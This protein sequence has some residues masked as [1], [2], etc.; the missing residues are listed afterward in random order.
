ML[1]SNL[2][3]SQTSVYILSDDVGISK[4]TF[5]QWANDLFLEQK[6]TTLEEFTIFH[7]IKNSAYPENWQSKKKLVSYLPRQI[8][9]D[10][11]LCDELFN[12]IQDKRSEKTKLFIGKGSFDCAIT[13]WNIETG[14]LKLN[15]ISE[16]KEK[17]DEELLV[18]KSLKKKLTLIFYLP[19]KEDFSKPIISFE[20][21]TIQGKSNEPLELNASFSGITKNISWTPSNFLSCDD[22][23]TPTAQVKETTTFTVSG[24]N[25]MGCESEKSSITVEIKEKCKDFNAPALLYKLK[26][27]GSFYKA[28]SDGYRWK[29][30]AIQPGSPEYY[31]VCMKNCGENFKVE[32]LD[33]NRPIW[34][35]TFLRE[36]IEEGQRPHID[37]PDKFIFKISVINVDAFR[38]PEFS[39]KFYKFRITSSDEDGN[40]YDTYVSPPTKFV[41]C[42]FYEY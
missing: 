40:N 18:N 10:Y 1:F 7:N 36:D 17:L 16:I 12:L 14:Q 24:E 23:K 27:A 28:M 11:V 2:I 8:N 30:A 5:K 41:D 34:G 15:S 13:N 26:G 6:K 32:I 31:L 42:G 20:E 22:C 4:S 29:I 37:F 3:L 38:S 21:D 33:E 19:G 9:C 25:E 35:D 39:R